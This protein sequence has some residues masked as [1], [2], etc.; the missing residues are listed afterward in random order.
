MKNDFKNI[1]KLSVLTASQTDRKLKTKIREHLAFFSKNENTNIVS[2]KS[3][4][5]THLRQLRLKTVFMITPR[6]V[7]LLQRNNS[8]NHS[9]CI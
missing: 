8:Y 4:F 1:K 3:N 6:Y 7:C 5:V 2:T 9:I